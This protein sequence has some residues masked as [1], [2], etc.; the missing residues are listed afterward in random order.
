VIGCTGAH[1]SPTQPPFDSASGP[2]HQ[3]LWQ[4]LM[5]SNMTPAAALLEAKRAFA[6]RLP[7]VTDPNELAIAYK[8]LAQFTCLGLGC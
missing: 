2:F 6:D 7:A 4:L 8:T 1:Y 5:M 3:S